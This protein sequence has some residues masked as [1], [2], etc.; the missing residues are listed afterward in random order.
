M[1]RPV[2]EVYRLPL[3]D[4][5]NDGGNGD[6]AG[7]DTAALAAAVCAA[8]GGVSH[9]ASPSSGAPQQD[10][11]AI[12]AEPVAPSEDRAPQDAK[13]HTALSDLRRTSTRQVVLVTQPSRRDLEQWTERATSTMVRSAGGSVRLVTSK[14]QSCRWV[15][16]YKPVVSHSGWLIK[17]GH[18]IR[19]FKRRL[20]CILDHELVYHDSHDATE[21]RG[22][23]DLRKRTTVQ[24]LLHSG[25]SLS[26]GSYQMV[27]Y[28]ID[29]HDREVWIKKLQEQGVELLPASAK[30]ARLIEEQT[31]NAEKKPIIF[32][33]W[34]RK[35][36]QVLKTTKRRWFELAG[37]TLTYYSH[38]EGGTKKGSLEIVD[39]QISHLDTLKSGERFS[40]VVHV[41]GRELV[42]HA[43]SQ[44]ERALWVA[45]LSSVADSATSF[46]SET[47]ESFSSINVADI[48]RRRCSCTT[49][50][51]DS[52][53]GSSSLD[54]SC[55][56]CM[57]SFISKS[58]DALVDV[59]RE[60]QLILASPYSPEG[61]TTAA[62]LKEHAGKPISNDTLRKFM[63]GLA[64]YMI[65]TRLNELRVLGGR[66][67][68]AAPETPYD[69]D[70]NVADDS[71]EFTERVMAIVNEQ[72][73][74]RVFFPHY[75]TVVENIKEQTRIESKRLRG[76]IEVLQSKPQ[77]FF[78]ISAASLSSSGWKSASLRL[79]EI[80]RVS[81][82]YMKRIELV[83]ACKEIYS[84][85]H[86]EHPSNAPMNADEFIP[87]FIYVLVQAQLSDPVLLKE[88]MTF[89]DLGCTQGE[90]AYF[91]TCLE[92]AIE[93]IR[94]LL[95][96]ETVIL[97]A[98]QKLGIEFR[99]DEYEQIIV[100]SRLVPGGQAEQTGG[101]NIGAV[102]VA[103]NGLLVYEMELAEVTKL[104]VDAEGD[105]EFCFLSRD[106]FELRFGG[107][108]RRIDDNDDDDDDEGGTWHHENADERAESIETALK[109]T[110]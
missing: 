20:F 92:I 53:I 44:E 99:R 22:R 13:P 37:T 79:K 10:P 50:A 107:A 46:E 16:E 96:A 34:L 33:G 25:F 110:A 14:Q 48:M 5:V 51:E 52:G 7:G 103:I 108:K 2:I 28:A 45:S 64:D 98:S 69:L 40:F 105:V 106:E 35:R 23:I 47:S 38:P 102:L 109:A 95:I 81:L 82:P 68:D 59:T 39:A 26:Q 86:D 21:V 11:M 80:D 63:S 1:S 97:D 94:S 42:L 17:R 73:E 54:G 100:V 77:S 84:I 70:S 101:I 76:K 6:A 62:F 41:P 36:G 78:G 30:T 31:H 74:E 60:V 18:S 66:S 49:N 89:F 12:D 4:T 61:S 29:A 24:C 56:R 57:S 85:Y 55:R 87:A 88:M 3:R 32:S 8:V 58:E 15:L 104:V 90:A 9:S 27:L 83:A 72:I 65:S 93:Y 91:V 71:S 67:N 19:N 75:R 43:D